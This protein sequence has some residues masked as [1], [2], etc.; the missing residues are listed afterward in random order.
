MNSEDF[1]KN[2]NNYL[3]KLAG[4]AVKENKLD[5]EKLFYFNDQLFAVLNLNREPYKLSVVCDKKL[6]NLLKSRYEEVVNPANLYPGKWITIILTGQL[7]INEVLDLFRHAYEI[8][9]V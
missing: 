5:Q 4:I 2:F 6:A 8:S 7:T 3:A 9:Q 1:L